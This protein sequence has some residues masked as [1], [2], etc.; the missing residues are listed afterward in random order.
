MEYNALKSTFLGKIIL[1]LVGLIWFFI[2][3]GLVLI[4]FDEYKLSGLYGIGLITVG[5]LFF[6]RAKVYVFK[7][8]KFISFGTKHMSERISLI[9]YA[10]YFLILSGLLVSF[11]IEI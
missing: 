10:G 2:L 7:K 1:G 3:I 9:Y 5:F 8:G 11:T 4:I 6:L